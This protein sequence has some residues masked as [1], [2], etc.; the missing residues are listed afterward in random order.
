MAATKQRGT[1]QRSSSLPS[2]ASSSGTN[3]VGIAHK[4]DHLIG[5]QVSNW[6]MRI[7][8][9]IIL[10]TP[11]C[12]NYS[13]VMLKKDWNKLFLFLRRQPPR[14]MCIIRLCLICKYINP[15]T[16]VLNHANCYSTICGP[17]KD[18]KIDRML[19]LL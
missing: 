4:Y 17:E 7:L 15:V 16:I 9:C 12:R 3:A 14:Y 18:C 11:N 5:E 8:R 10:L 1:L 13:F 19:T 2:S 6:N